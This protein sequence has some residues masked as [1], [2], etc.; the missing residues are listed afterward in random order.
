VIDRIAACLILD[1]YLRSGKWVG[2]RFG[3]QAKK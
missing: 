3:G 2:A 1:G